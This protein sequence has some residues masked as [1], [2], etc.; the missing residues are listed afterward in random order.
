MQFYVRITH[1]G[2]ESWWTGKM[3]SLGEIFCFGATSTMAHIHGTQV[4]FGCMFLE[5]LL[6]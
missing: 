5:L 4:F 2:V 1:Y 3:S 6:L